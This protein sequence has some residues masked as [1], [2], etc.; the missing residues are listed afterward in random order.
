[1][2]PGRRPLLSLDLGR[3]VCL[4]RPL[5]PRLFNPYPLSSPSPYI[6]PNPQ[7]LPHHPSLLPVNH[8]LVSSPMLLASTI[9]LASL[10]PKHKNFSTRSTCVNII[11]LQQ[12][13]SSPRISIASPSSI[14]FVWGLPVNA[15]ASMSGTSE[16]MR[17]TYLEK[18]WAMG[19]PQVKLRI[20]VIMLVELGDWWVIGRE[21]GGLA[22]S[23]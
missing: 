22:V 11:L 1:M 20:G 2:D 3:F 8:P 5:P 9:L 14:S 15:V 7:F 21:R 18:R 10:V 13:R 17:S 6:L 12:Y 19:L 4:P 23:G 16:E